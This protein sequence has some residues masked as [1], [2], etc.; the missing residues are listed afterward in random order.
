MKKFENLT[1]EEKLE[2]EKLLLQKAEDFWIQT[3]G[4]QEASDV[5]KIRLLS[6]QGK[7]NDKLQHDIM[8]NYFEKQGLWRDGKTTLEER[9]KQLILEK[10]EF[11][12][13][14][15]QVRDSKIKD[16]DSIIAKATMRKQELKKIPVQL[17]EEFKIDKEKILAQLNEKLNLL[18]NTSKEWIDK[19]IANIYDNFI[20]TT[21]NKQ[22]ELITTARNEL[23][24]LQKQQKARMR[25]E[26]ETFSAELEAELTVLNYVENDESLIEK[27]NEEVQL[28]NQ[29]I[30]KIDNVLSEKPIIDYN[31]EK[32]EPFGEVTEVIIDTPI[33]EPEEPEE[34][35]KVGLEFLTVA[36][37]KEVADSNNI[38]YPARIL[39]ADLIALLRE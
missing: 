17:Q 35:P 10:Q 39:K 33:E 8:V 4:K 22:D 6:R 30:N 5:D 25:H 19:E 7:L 31:P 29:E 24:T 15:A 18:Y 37:L 28:I 2:H 26:V 34:P 14:I 12:K 23:E 36:Q 11:G 32:E 16:I 3:F 38:Q 20:L 1:N 27:Y 9:K 21:K 13:K